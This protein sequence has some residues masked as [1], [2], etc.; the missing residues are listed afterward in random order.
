MS[1]ALTLLHDYLCSYNPDGPYIRIGKFDPEYSDPDED[2]CEDCDD[3][4]SPYCVCECSSNDGNHSCSDCGE[5]RSDYCY[6]E[7]RYNLPGFQYI[8]PCDP[9]EEAESY[10][11]LECQYNG[12]WK[13]NNPCTDCKKKDQC[14]DCEYAEKKERLA[15]ASHKKKPARVRAS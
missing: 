14:E 12:D 13:Q 9:C 11:F 15:S 8:S 5:Y 7:C 10:C 4:H 6:Q 1:E 3:Y 2:K